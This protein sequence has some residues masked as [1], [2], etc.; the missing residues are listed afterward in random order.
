LQTLFK[1]KKKE[2][3]KPPQKTPKNPQ[4]SLC[5]F[6]AFHLKR[7]SDGKERATGKPSAERDL[8]I[9]RGGGN[10]ISQGTR[11]F[12]NRRGKRRPKQQGK[13][14]GGLRWGWGRS[15]RKPSKK[16]RARDAEKKKKMKYQTKLKQAP[17]D[18]VGGFAKKTEGADRI[19]CGDLSKT[20]ERRKGAKTQKGADGAAGKMASWSK[21]KRARPGGGEEEPD[22]ARRK[23]QGG[24]GGEE[25]GLNDLS[26]EKPISEQEKTAR[27]GI[28]GSTY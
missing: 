17:L 16:K 15:F 2:P 27:R 23:R 10:F 5:A 19:I 11:E 4:K 3:K 20:E 21:K 18:G 28:G 26:Q 9:L 25:K 8:I 24:R 12:K 22:V 1:K 14:H 6:G 13:G 7:R